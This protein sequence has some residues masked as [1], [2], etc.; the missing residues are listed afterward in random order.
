MQL[1]G[2]DMN[3]EEEEEFNGEE[4]IQLDSDTDEDAPQNQLSD[5]KNEVVSKSG[6]ITPRLR[7]V[8]SSNSQPMREVSKRTRARTFEE[9]T[10]FDTPITTQSKSSS[11]ENTTNISSSNVNHLCV[12]SMELVALPKDKSQ[13]IAAPDLDPILAITFAVCEDILNSESY[14]EGAIAVDEKP[15]FVNKKFTLVTN[16]MELL[17]EFASI[18]KR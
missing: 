9:V 2:F 12:M 5:F 6:I 11:N 7:P 15:A 4:E 18:V 10:Q 14:H 1:R 8:S 3:T 17:E 16:E 13:G